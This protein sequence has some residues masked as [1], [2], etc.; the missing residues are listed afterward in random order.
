[1]G[2]SN[3]TEQKITSTTAVMNKVMN[4]IKSRTSVQS[5][6]ANSMVQQVSIKVKGTNF[7]GS[8]TVNQKATA[9]MSGFLSVLSQA[10][11][12]LTSQNLIDIAEQL[13]SA[14]EQSNEGVGFGS[15]SSKQEI[16]SDNGSKVKFKGRVL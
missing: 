3:S 2:G 9:G 10:D 4:D 16:I 6:K 8:I 13:N 5:T 12:S 15:N 1:M 11:Y 14:T 7:G